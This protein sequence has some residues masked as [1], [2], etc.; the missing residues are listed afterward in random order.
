MD[1]IDG[2]VP[3]LQRRGLMQTKDTPGPLREKIFGEGRLPVR[4]PGA[5]YRRG[6]GGGGHQWRNLG[7]P[8][9]RA[10]PEYRQE[11]EDQLSTRTC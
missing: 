11:S 7:K 6:Y 8:K 2:V 9:Y 1:F 5:G 3:V 4:H 10:F